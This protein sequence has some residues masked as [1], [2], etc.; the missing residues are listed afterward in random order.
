MASVSEAIVTWLYTNTT[1]SVDKT[2]DTDQ[3]ATEAAA[4]GLYKTP[5]TV[6]KPFI[7]GSRDITAYYSFL[8]RQKSAQ[9][10]TRKASQSWLEAL[11]AWVRGKNMAS[12]LP[13][14]GT[15]RTCNYVGIA[16]SY[17]LQ[18]TEEQD[19]VYHL[20]IAVNYTETEE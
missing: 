17:A 6:I 4:Y 2:I 11:E 1:I 15:G 12:D 5:Q 10:A 9:E 14:L 7:D 13:A 3:L 19:A 20:T 8:A 16:N 18:S